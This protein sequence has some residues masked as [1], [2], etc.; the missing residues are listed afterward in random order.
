MCRVKRV[1]IL[2]YIEYHGKYVWRIDMFHSDTFI[3]VIYMC[4]KRKECSTYIP[5]PTDVCLVGL[6]NTAT[7][8]PV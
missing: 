4:K 8:E 5:P 6:L 2:T 3:H 7:G 1:L